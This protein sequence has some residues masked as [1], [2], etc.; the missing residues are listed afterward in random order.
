MSIVKKFLNEHFISVACGAAAAFTFGGF[1]W[2]FFA[3][4]TAGTDFLIL[5]FDDLNGI[6]SIGQI[7]FI[8]FMGIFGLLIIGMN[9]AIAREFS[10]RGDTIR[11]RF[12]SRFLAAMTLV[13]GVLLFIAFAAII[14]VNV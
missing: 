11:G 3:L 8:V 6:T 9:F 14:N 13:F 2:A 7:G 5:H 4:C 10:S 1:I 12:F